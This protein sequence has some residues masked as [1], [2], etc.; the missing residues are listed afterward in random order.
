MMIAEAE[1][2]KKNLTDKYVVV[3]QSV[4]ELRRFI[5]LTGRVK[6]VNMNCRALVEFDG[7]VDITWYDIDPSCL[8][9]VDAPQ[10]KQAK[11]EERKETKAAAPKK[12]A[13]GGASPLEL[14][15]QQGAAGAGGE[16]KKLSPL[17]L[18]R[19]QG[20]AGAKPAATEEKTL[21]PLEQA[22]QQGA[23]GSKPAASPPA[24]KKLSPLEMARQQGAAK[25]GDAAPAA[26]E[27]PPAESPEVEATPETTADA[28]EKATGG[29]AETPTSTAEIIALA[30]QQGPFKG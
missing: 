13:T 27:E 7:P 22:R 16:A 28:E 21:S 2:L 12:A 5:G 23:A 19:Q 26:N 15:R 14:A 1:V 24:E 18:A 4:P 11:A 25:S 10:P 17:E 20:A 30:R 29:A 3:N 8:T 6:T 9:V